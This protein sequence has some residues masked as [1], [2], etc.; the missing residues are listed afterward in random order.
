MPGV[1][2]ILIVYL[3]GFGVPAL[4]LTGLPSSATTLGGTALAPPG[5]A[6]RVGELTFGGQMLRRVGQGRRALAGLAACTLA[7]LVQ[8]SAVRAQTVTWSPGSWSWFGDPRAVHLGGPSGETIVGWIDWT[9]AVTV[10][11]YNPQFG[12]LS[13]QVVGHAYHDDHSDPSILVEPDARVTVFWS[14]HNGAQ[15]NYRTTIRPDDISAWTPV[16]QLRQDIA[17]PDGFTYPNPVLLPAEN[18][19]TYLFWRGADW[20]TDFARRTSAGVW[21]PAHVAVRAAGQRPYL[22]VADNGTDTIALAFTNGHSRNTLTSVYYAAYRNGSLWTADGRWIARMG[23]PPI[24]PQR[25]QLVYDANATHVSAWVWDIAFGRRQRPVIVYATFP[26]RTDAIYW[27]AVFNG[28]RWVSHRMTDGGG[29]ISPGTIEYEYSGGMALDHSNPSTVYLSIQV[30]GGWEIQ[31]W[32]TVDGGI[33]WTHDTIIG[34]DGTE[35]VRPVVP[36]GY[37]G[38]PMGL[39]W[40]RGAYDTY[41]TYRTSIAF[42]Q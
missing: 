7:C 23:D 40:L 36:R 18:D 25:A 13:D 22:K 8:T 19:E 41:T 29:S 1:P 34:A 21:G 32:V 10:G 38:G 24:A 3:I 4:D 11:A 42:L 33:H 26:K 31:R 12:L 20:S 6:P 35:N 28:S 2:T 30:H 37:H 17:G 15:M 14:A 5:S 39:L 16:A 9:G 27:Y